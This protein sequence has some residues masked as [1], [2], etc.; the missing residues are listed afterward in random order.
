V[1]DNSNVAFA[2]WCAVFALVAMLSKRGLMQILLCAKPLPIGLCFCVCVCLSVYLS[3]CLSA[4]VSVYLCISVSLSV[5]MSL[6]V[7]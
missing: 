2:R 6:H 3:V 1:Q 5:C 7:P 4:C